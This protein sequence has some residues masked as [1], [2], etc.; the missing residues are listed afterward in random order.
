MAFLVCGL[1]LFIDDTQMARVYG[2]MASLVSIQYCE[3]ALRVWH[4]RQGLLGLLTP[5]LTLLGGT[6]VALVHFALLIY[7][8][9]S[10][11]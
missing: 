1:I 3:F 7:V 2:L 11:L 8:I 10:Q 5:A 4:K 6:A 9:G